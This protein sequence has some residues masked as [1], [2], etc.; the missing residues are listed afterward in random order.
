[1]IFLRPN[2]FPLSESLAATTALVRVT[3][4][5]SS[6]FLTFFEKAG[7]SSRLLRQLFYYA[8]NPLLSSLTTCYSIMLLVERV[9]QVLKPKFLF[10]INMLVVLLLCHQI[11]ES[12]SHSVTT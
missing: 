3:F 10:I 1:M 8:I 9:G 5:L 7:Q 6:K 11:D 2:H 12:L 4:L